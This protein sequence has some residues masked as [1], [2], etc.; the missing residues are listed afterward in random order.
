[1]IQDSAFRRFEGNG[2]RAASGAGRFQDTRLSGVVME[3][4]KNSPRKF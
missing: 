1:M 3:P 2:L 4:L